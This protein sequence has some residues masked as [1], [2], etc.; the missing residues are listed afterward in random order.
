MTQAVKMSELFYFHPLDQLNR[1]F[2]L[3]QSQTSNKLSF[4]ATHTHPLFVVVK[5]C[6]LV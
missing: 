4:K 6:M 2:F 3:R 1:S 5:R